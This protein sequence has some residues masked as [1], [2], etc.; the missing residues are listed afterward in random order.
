MRKFLILAVILL[1]SSGCK[2]VVE[3]VK[4]T[5]ISGTVTNGG[6][7][8]NGAIVLLLEC[9]S[10]TQ[11]MSLSNGSVTNSSGKYEIIRVED[12]TY[13]IPAIKDTGTIGKYDKGID[14]IGWYGER[15]TLT[16]L[17][18][19]TPVTVTGEDITGIDIDTLYTAP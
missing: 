10:L 6:E 1:V 16:N 5:T 18:K 12:G 2:K 11:G 14:K 15:D 8:V 19:P 17:T 3:E 9:D 4:K 7:P 13:Y